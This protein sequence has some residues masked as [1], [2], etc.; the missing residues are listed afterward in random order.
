MKVPTRK[1]VKC[2]KCGYWG[3]SRDT[4]LKRNLNKRPYYCGFCGSRDFIEIISKG[5]H[6]II[7]R[8]SEDIEKAVQLLKN[9]TAT[10]NE[11]LGESIGIPDTFLKAFRDE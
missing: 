9:K 6:E 4:F 1:L 2:H 7:C 10:I 11:I 5:Y 8:K 3:F